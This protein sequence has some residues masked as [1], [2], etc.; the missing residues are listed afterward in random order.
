MN[1]VIAQCFEP[2]GIE[3]DT[4]HADDLFAVRPA[5]LSEP[6]G[7]TV[8]TTPEDVAYEN[9]LAD[10]ETRI[11][12]DRSTRLQILEAAALVEGELIAVAVF[13]LG[14]SSAEKQSVVDR[15]IFSWGGREAAEKIIRTAL[16]AHGELTS[17]DQRNFQHIKELVELRNLVAHGRTETWEAND[18]DEQDGELGRLIHHRSAKG[19]EGWRRL[20]FSEAE[21]K[22][23]AGREAAI[24]LA[25][26]LADIT[27]RSQ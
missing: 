13:Y 24:A 5:Q 22:S 20:N 23:K 25:R 27:R 11:E 9:Y 4:P 2:S 19:T 15:L 12:R 21:D 16:A 8:S 10:R 26:H 7:T 17:D 1:H 18:P 3:V 6:K 14:G